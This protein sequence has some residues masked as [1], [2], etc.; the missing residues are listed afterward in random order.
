MPLGA[1]I[2]NCATILATAALILG[3]FWMGAG[4]WSGLGAGLLFNLNYS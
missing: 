4:A 1:Y 2:E 3:L